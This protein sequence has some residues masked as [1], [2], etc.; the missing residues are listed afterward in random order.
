MAVL[1][2]ADKTRL[3]GRRTI[4]QGDQ[5]PSSDPLSLQQGSDPVAGVIQTDCADADHIQA[6]LAHIGGDTSG[7][8]D[9]FFVVFLAEHDDG[10][11]RADPFRIA[12]N[13]AVENEITDQQNPLT[14]ERLDQ[15]Y[16]TGNQVA[17]LAA[18]P[19]D[20]YR[21]IQRIQALGRP[22]RAAAQR[23]AHIVSAS[24][25]GVNRASG[26][27]IDNPQKNAGIEQGSH[28]S[29]SKQVP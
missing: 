8:A 19:A 22:I 29:R 1:G 26:L 6:Q 10:R 15:L 21:N 23:P 20:R 12:V 13:V 2:Q 3:G 28:Q 7:S 25:E 9:T 27:A 4:A 16:Q 14:A 17:A 18:A 5:P 24:T 11:F